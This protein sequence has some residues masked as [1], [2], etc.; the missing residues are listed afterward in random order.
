[1]TIRC[2]GCRYWWPDKADDPAKDWEIKGIGQCEKAIELRYSTKFVN[3]KNTRR[4]NRQSI[5]PAYVDQMLFCD[6][7]MNDGGDVSSSVWTRHDFFCAHHEPVKPMESRMTDPYS[8]AET[9][10]EIVV[11]ALRELKRLLSDPAIGVRPPVSFA[12][13][14]QRTV[15]GEADG[16]MNDQ[17]I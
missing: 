9:I 3:Y 1:M 16:A 13:I 10:D 14:V 5:I 11:V 15:P 8:Q 12:P 17:V 2:D 6:G 7:A 4:G